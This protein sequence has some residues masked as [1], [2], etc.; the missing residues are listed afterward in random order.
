MYQQIS[1]VHVYGGIALMWEVMSIVTVLA[2]ICNMEE[3]VSTAQEKKRVHH[4]S[5]SSHL[6]DMQKYHQLQQRQS[7][8]PL[9][10]SC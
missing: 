7:P 3:I 1:D 4:L 10:C 9:A 6:T 5:Y 2:N 8:L